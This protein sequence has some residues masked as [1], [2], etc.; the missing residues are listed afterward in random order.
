MKTRNGF[1]SNSS[2]TSFCVYG[3][4]VICGKTLYENIF[5][6]KEP[7][8]EKIKNCTHDFDRETCKFCPECGKKS[9]TIKEEKIFYSSEVFESHFKQYDLDFVYGDETCEGNNY[10]VGVNLC[11]SKKEDRTLEKLQEAKVKLETLFPG[12]IIDFY[13]G[14]REG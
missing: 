8:I 2:T 3:V 11:D 14:V 6:K 9:W 12:K 7:K 13:N 10:I 1:V 5:G 4:S